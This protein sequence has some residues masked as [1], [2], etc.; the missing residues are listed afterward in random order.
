MARV[1][2]LPVL[3]AIIVAMLG[4]SADAQAIASS[5]G[6]QSVSVTVYRD[7]NRTAER[8]MNLGWLNG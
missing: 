4:A 1:S 3:A 6:P 7:P 8:A 5:A 2:R